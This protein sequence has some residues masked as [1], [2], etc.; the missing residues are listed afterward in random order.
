MTPRNAPERFPQRRRPQ[1][2][3]PGGPPV[4]V[5][6]QQEEDGDGSEGH[7]D[8]G[9]RAPLPCRRQAA[10]GDRDTQEPP[11]RGDEPD[12][13]GDQPSPDGWLKNNAPMAAKWKFNRVY[14]AHQMTAI[15]HIR[16]VN[17]SA[18][19]ASATAEAPARI[20]VPRRPNR[21]PPRPACTFTTNTNS[22]PNPLITPTAAPVQPP[23]MW[24]N[25]SA[26]STCKGVKGPEQQP[27]GQWR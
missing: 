13:A 20:Q 1:I 15:S 21:A 8:A 22:A 23:P 18:N 3:S 6:Q 5:V 19:T 11:D 9:D 7:P 10:A 27:I 17:M 4:R 16:V 14:V 2:H 12:G 24:E 25:C 26:S